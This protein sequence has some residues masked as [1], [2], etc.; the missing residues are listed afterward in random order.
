[1]VDCRS[2]LILI[3]LI[4]DKPCQIADLYYN[5]HVRFQGGISLEKCQLDQI[6]NYQF[7]AIIDVHM[8]N[9]GKIVLNI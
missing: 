9:L 2:L 4:S 5:K 1:M 3:Y 8:V 6:Q 7:E